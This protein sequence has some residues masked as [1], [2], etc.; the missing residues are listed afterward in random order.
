MSAVI[1][2]AVADLASNLTGPERGGVHV[3]VGLSS[4]DQ[5]D[6]FRPVAGGDAI[7]RQGL[8]VGGGQRARDTVPLRLS[9]GLA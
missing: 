6:D 9:L 4:P 1:G 2:V 8:D 7:D 5:G 3:G